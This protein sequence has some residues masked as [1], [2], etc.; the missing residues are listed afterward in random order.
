MTVDQGIAPAEK[1]KAH[2]LHPLCNWNGIQTIPLEGYVAIV[3]FALMLG[4]IWVAA[5]RIVRGR[6]P[7]RF[8]RG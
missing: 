7:A 3:G 1:M 5:R 2:S 8:G 4:F 6:E